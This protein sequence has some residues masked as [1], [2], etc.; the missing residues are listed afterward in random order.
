MEKY[1]DGILSLQ[2]SFQICKPHTEEDQ[3]YNNAVEYLYSEGLIERFADTKNKT[4]YRV[5]AAGIKARIIGF[6]KWQSAESRNA[7]NHTIITNNVFIGNKNNQYCQAHGKT[8]K[9]G[10]FANILSIISS[11][12]GTI[13]LKF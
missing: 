12:A 11:I 9:I 6:K 13:G 3:L 10:I 7:S 5:G 8:E 1:F 2:H 4:K